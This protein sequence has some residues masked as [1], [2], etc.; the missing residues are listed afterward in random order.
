MT[1][2]EYRDRFIQPVYDH[3]IDRLEPDEKPFDQLRDA[4][5]MTVHLLNDFASEMLKALTSD[6]PARA[7]LC[8]LYG[9]AYAMGLNIT[10]DVTMTE[11]S[12][13]LGYERATLS[14]IAVAW[15]TA[16]DLKPSWH[17]KAASAN[18]TYARVRR[19]VVQS[20]GAKPPPV[21]PRG[22]SA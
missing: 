14:K 13:Q 21:P 20:N 18:E 12:D 9:I 10:G 17:Q 7:A 19:G 11:R 5:L 6:D 1:E 16:H 22:R 8:R 2:Q 15:N 4:R 3:P